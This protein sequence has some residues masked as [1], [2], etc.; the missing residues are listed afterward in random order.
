MTTR[1]KLRYAAL[2]VASVVAITSGCQDEEP[3]PEEVFRGFVENIWRGEDAAALEAVAPDTRARLLEPLDDVEQSIGEAHGLEPVDMLIVTRLD[4]P[5]ELQEVEVV[6]ELPDPLE[7]GSRV[8]LALRMLDD[9]TG[10]ATMV[11]QGGRWYVDLPLDEVDTEQVLVPLHREHEEPQVAPEEAP[12]AEE[13]T[14]HSEEEG[15]VER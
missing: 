15:K 2:C 3:G 6:G 5:H 4:N 11:Y 10:N 12:A 7:E 13:S 9:R 1:N 8:E 14:E